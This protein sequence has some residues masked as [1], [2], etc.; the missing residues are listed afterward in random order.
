MMKRYDRL[1]NI[2]PKAR[3][4]APPCPM[5]LLLQQPHLQARQHA[6]P[7]R[8]QSDL[9]C[10]YKDARQ[11][12]GCKAQLHARYFETHRMLSDG[13]ELRVN[14]DVRQAHDPHEGSTCQIY[15]HHSS[16]A[17][18]FDVSVH[19]FCPLQQAKSI[20]ALQTSHYRWIISK[21]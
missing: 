1:V 17:A 20:R 15:S 4:K 19:S 11:I 8:Q 16:Q 9:R 6:V 14:H 2:A 7:E 12:L 5:R 13:L 21:A 18:F 3:L 10:A